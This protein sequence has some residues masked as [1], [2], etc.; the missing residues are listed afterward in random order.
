L[1]KFL[2]EKF[3]DQTASFETGVFLVDVELHKLVKV[4][5]WFKDGST[6]KR[7]IKKGKGA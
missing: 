2:T 3:P 7:I 4:E 1:W 5:D 6:M